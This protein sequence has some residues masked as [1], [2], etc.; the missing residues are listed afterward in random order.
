M[1]ERLRCSADAEQTMP[2]GPV[3]DIGRFPW[4]GL[5]QHSFYIAGRVHFAITGAVLIH[6][7]FAIAAAE[8]IA[9]IEPTELKNNT[10]LILWG[11]KG[12]ENQKYAVDVMDYILHPQYQERLTFATIALLDLVGWSETQFNDWKA[13][14][15]PICMPVKGGGLFTD[16]Y[17]I[18]FTDT[19]KEMQKEVY[20][21]KF[22]DDQDCEEFYYKA[23]LSYGKTNPVNPVCAVS[24][25]IT[26]P[27]VWDSGT[28]LVTRQSW[29]FW[30]LLG[31]ALR[32]PGC[33]APTRFLNIHDYLPWINDVISRKAYEDYEDVYKLAMRRLSPYKFILFKG[34]TKLPK[35]IGQ[36]SRRA[37]GSV[38]Y[39]DSSEFNTNMNLDCK[40]RTN[41][42]IWLEHNCHPD[43]RGL[44]YNQSRAGERE[45]L[46]CFVYFKTSAFVE[47]RFIFSFSATIEVT[48]FGVHETTRNIPNPFKSTQHTTAWWPTTSKFIMSQWVPTNVW[49]YD[50]ETSSFPKL[51][52]LDDYE[53]CLAKEDGLCSSAALAPFNTTLDPANSPEQLFERCTDFYMQAENY[54]ASLKSLDYCRTHSHIIEASERPPTSAEVIFKNVVYTLIIANIVGTIYHNFAGDNPN[55]NWR[56]L[57]FIREGGDPRQAALVP[58]EGLRVMALGFTTYAHACVIHYMYHIKNPEYL[59]ELTQ[60]MDGIYLSAGT[61]LIQVFV[62][63]TSFLTGYNLLIYSQKQELGLHMLP[64]CIIKRL[65]RITPVHIFIV[66]FAAT[67]WLDTR[68]G[69]LVSTTIGLESEACTSKFW[70]HV[71]LVNNIV[72]TDKYCVVPT[73]FLPV[74]MHMY[75]VACAFTLVLW[76]RRCFAVRLYLVLFFVTCLLNGF[77]AYMKDYRSMIYLATPEHI[78]RIFRDNLS[79]TEFYISSW[80]ALPACFL[81]L[82]LAHIQFALDERKIKLSDYKWFVYLHYTMFPVLFTWA[83]TGIYAREHSSSDLFNAVYIAFDRPLFCI[84][85]CIGLLGAFHID[86]PIRKFYSWRGWRTMARM[87]LTVMLLHWCVDMT[88][89]TR[90]VAYGT[91]A[92]DMHSIFVNKNNYESK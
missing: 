11:S 48:L 58:M 26:T 6:P 38:L 46:L 85:M 75:I 23:Q 78:R 33:G 80:G 88:I 74:N 9:R 32:S 69:P 5:V 64:L 56:R 40:I 76:R 2:E 7:G 90:S 57:T 72:E 83:L 49:W 20:K 25:N 36:C 37:R 4:L 86:G 29:G 89:A 60:R 21:M 19:S 52:Q 41:A 77:V 65:V 53:R 43:M 8:D 28:A 1:W 70:S 27:C 30:K 84:L 39:K 62:M 67:W 16:M 24:E 47:V 42:A 44:A 12:K 31:F 91:S 22:V 61:S 81:G 63:M 71:F 13:P 17:A 73:W 3:S 45:R 79:F 66:G 92:T 55:N 14:V 87:S 51:F 15:L 82:I 54:H 59:E 68:G 34:T 10:K 35:G 18:K 50:A